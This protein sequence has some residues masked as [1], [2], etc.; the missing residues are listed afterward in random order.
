MSCVLAAGVTRGRRKR[1]HDQGIGSEARCE[2]ADDLASRPRIC[3]VTIPIGCASD[4]LCFCLP[5][6]LQVG[7][8]FAGIVVLSL[9]SSLKTVLR[10]FSLNVALTTRSLPDQLR[11]PNAS[12]LA[13]RSTKSRPP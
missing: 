6:A 2:Q 7:C 10:H 1:D 5:F 12:V 3:N 4:E 13:P 9:F 11:C 8:V